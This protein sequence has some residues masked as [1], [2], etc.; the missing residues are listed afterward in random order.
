M[1]QS[2]CKNAMWGDVKMK[3]IEID[4]DSIPEIVWRD[5]GRTFLDLVEKFYEDPDNMK[6]FEEWRANRNA[7]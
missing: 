4:Y 3:K 7:V 1:Y 5:I 2:H 6:A